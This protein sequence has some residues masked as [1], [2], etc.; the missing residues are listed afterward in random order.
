MIIWVQEANFDCV[1]KSPISKWFE[2]GFWIIWNQIAI[3]WNQKVSILK[4]LFETCNFNIEFFN[5]I[6]NFFTV[7]FDEV[8]I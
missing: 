7:I 8:L 1:C 5:I 2:M 4:Q 6:T 3:I